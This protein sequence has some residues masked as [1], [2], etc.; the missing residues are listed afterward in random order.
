M[1]LVLGRSA[2]EIPG[3][4][5]PFVYHRVVQSMSGGLEFYP[6]L[7]EVFRAY[8][9]GPVDSVLAVR[10]PLGFWFLALI[11][12]DNVTWLL[13]LAAATVAAL[14]LARTLHNPVLAITVILFFES[15][16]QVAWTAPELWASILVVAAVGLALDEQWIPAAVTATIATSVREL[17][18]LVLVGIAVSQRRSGRS[19]VAPVVGLG[20]VTAFYLAHWTRASSYLVPVGEGRQADLFGTGSFPSGVLAM[21]STWLPGGVVVGV[22]L[23]AATLA[24]AHRRDRLAL[25]APVLALVLAGVLVDRPE[26]ATFVIPLTLALGLDELVDRIGRWCSLHWRGANR[27]AAARS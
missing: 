21:M 6:S 14:L 8:G 23:F 12:N 13:M 10:S 17:A 22:I 1:M 5:D 16:G 25:L 27:S 26:W 19:V 20:V 3:N 15:V 7:D 9:M 11:G 24:W 2:P 18:V 4:I